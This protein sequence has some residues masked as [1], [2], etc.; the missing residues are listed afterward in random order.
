[1]RRS[2]QSA[3]TSPAAQPA[4]GNSTKAAGESGAQNASRA[5]SSA[6]VLP[7]QM[8]STQS[9]AFAQ[10]LATPSEYRLVIRS[11]RLSED[12]R[13]L[14]MRTVRSGLAEF[15]LPQMPLSVFEQKGAD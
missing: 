9:P 4:I 15:G 12:M 6:T 7:V 13:D 1:I 8:A 3:S 10:V 14:V 2:I 11:L 5:N